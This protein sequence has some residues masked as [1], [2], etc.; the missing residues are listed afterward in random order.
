[1]LVAHALVVQGDQAFMGASSLQAFALGI[2]SREAWYQRPDRSSAAFLEA[3][4]PENTVIFLISLAQL[5]LLALVFDSRDL[6]RKVSDQG[7]ASLVCSAIS[8]IGLA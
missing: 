6:H 4:S 7:L 8:S 1:M 2:L 3:R 5:V